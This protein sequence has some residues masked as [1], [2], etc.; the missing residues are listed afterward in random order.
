[1]QHRCFANPDAQL[2]LEIA[3]K[4]G[5]PATAA[6]E[7]KETD[8]GPKVEVTVTVR[9]FLDTCLDCG[10]SAVDIQQELKQAS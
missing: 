7:I 3:A 1:M 6:L 5:F 2:L 4:K 8:G 9:F 10:R